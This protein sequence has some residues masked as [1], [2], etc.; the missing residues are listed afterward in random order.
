MPVRIQPYRAELAPDFERLNVE[1]LE[2]YFEVEPIDRRV[3]GD[4]Q[5]HI[6]DAG[7]D[8]LFAALDGDVVGTCALLHH[9]DGRYEL[10]KMAVTE[11]AQGRGVGRRLLDAVLAR[12]EALSGKC[13]FLESHSSLVT[14]VGLYERAGFAHRP[15]PYVS[16][17]ARADVYMEWQ[18]RSAGPDVHAAAPAP[19][20]DGRRGALPRR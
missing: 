11:S 10:T 5:R 12:F 13:L 15:R 4:P 6:M 8:I 2:R 20:G 1:W 19:G 3:L 17:Y 16:K 18:G 9:G 7:G 14:A